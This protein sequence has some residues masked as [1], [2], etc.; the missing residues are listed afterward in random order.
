M[1]CGYCCPISFITGT[2]QAHLQAAPQ[3]VQRGLHVLIRRKGRQHDQR[4]EGAHAHALLPA[5]HQVALRG[6]RRQAQRHGLDTRPQAAAQ[7]VCALAYAL[8]PL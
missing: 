5:G 2:V 3:R 7:L 4:L 8:T 6:P 1:S